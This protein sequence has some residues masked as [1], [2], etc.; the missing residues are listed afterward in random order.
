M[1]VVIL[2]YALDPHLLLALDQSRD[3]ARFEN[4]EW[5]VVI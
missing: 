1:V 4:P 2:G 3:V 5:H